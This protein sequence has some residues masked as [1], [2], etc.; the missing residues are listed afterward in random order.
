MSDTFKNI[1]V[2]IPTI[3]DLDFLEFWKDAFLHCNLII[4]EDREKKTVRPPYSSFAN[5]FHYCWNDISQEFGEKEWIF[6]RQNAGIRCYGFFKAYQMKADVIITIDDDCYP[7][8]KDFV[9]AHLEN[10][11]FRAHSRWVT[12]YPHPSWMYSRGVPYR[13]RQN[14]P[15]MVSHGLWS[16]ALDLD[17]HTEITL[18][19]LLAREPYPPIRQV[20]PSD[21]YYPMCSMNLAF[22][23]EVVPLMF[24]PMM[25]RDPNGSLW[26]YDR[27]DD[28]WAGLF[29]KKIM[30]HL[31]WAVVSGSP[32][33]EHRK[34]SLPG[35]NFEKE[36]T[37][38]KANETIWKRVDEV[39]LTKN[40]PKACYLELA[41]HIQFP[42]YG[43]FEKL[44]TAMN[45]WAD[46][47]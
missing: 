7:A 29:S 21:S 45:I 5:V 26:G 2:V 43:Y 16:G 41:E 23:R 46:L 37:G 10:L 20:I 32:F 47:F 34:A 3:R 28:I 1:F 12:T 30:D 35:E 42:K 31:G 8:E 38:M 22:R 39:R 9:R 4:V 33:V 44:R 17:A 14:L 13:I 18:K 25:G 15:V 24:F 40:N 11:A 27:F 6:S 36:K 19:T